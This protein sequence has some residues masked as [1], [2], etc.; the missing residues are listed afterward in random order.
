MLTCHPEL[1]NGKGVWRPL[2]KGR[3]IHRKIRTGV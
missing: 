3:K 2:S 1:R